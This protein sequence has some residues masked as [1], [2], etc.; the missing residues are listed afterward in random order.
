MS[1]D[2]LNRRH[3]A[4]ECEQGQTARAGWRGGERK[5]DRAQAR[6]DPPCQHGGGRTPII[7]SASLTSDSSGSGTARRVEERFRE[8]KPEVASEW[9][10]VAR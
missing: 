7:S 6:R 8:P 2:R 1:C 3:G 9:V 10:V 4:R 5:G